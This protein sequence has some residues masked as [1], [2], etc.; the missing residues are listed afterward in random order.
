[1]ARQTFEAWIPE[2]YGGPVITKIAQLSAVEAFARSEPMGTDTKHVARSG[3]MTFQG[4][5]AK[6]AA[7]PEDAN[8]NDEVLLTARKLGTVL[9]VADEDLKDIPQLPSVI[10]VKQL[11][12]A[13]AYAIGFDNACLGVTAAE[14]GTTIP[15]TSIYKSLTTTNAATSY[16]ANANRVQTAGTAAPVTYAQLSSLFAKL[17][18]GAFWDE[19]SM[20]VV[21]HPAFKA[22]M[23]NLLDST[24]AP[25]FTEFQSAAGAP[26][27]TLF[28]APVRWSLGA[29]THATASDTPTGNPLLFLLNTSLVIKGDRSGPEYMLAG[30]DSGPAF[31]TDEALL[32]VRTRRGFA[33]GHENAAA[34]LEILP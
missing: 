15:F 18:G 5:I 33:L 8:T 6:G 12:W 32:K 13:R 26:M 21:A 23:R 19:S 34:V 29:K 11:D 7:Y 4:A 28:G 17:E 31:L 14:N 16:T 27:S 20:V 10:Q 24:G 9:R 1:M 30:A 22:Q 25:I 2:E 3:G